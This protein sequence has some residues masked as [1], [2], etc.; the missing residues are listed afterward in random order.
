MMETTIEISMYPLREEYE[1]AIL[2]FVDFLNEQGLEVRVNETSTHLFVDYDLVFDALKEGIRA[3]F[4]KYGIAVFV[5]KV[6]NGNL[7]A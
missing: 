3:S 4:E 6:L 2:E 7:K 5:L 1:D